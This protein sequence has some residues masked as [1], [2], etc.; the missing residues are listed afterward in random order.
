LNYS[1]FRDLW[2]KFILSSLGKGSKYINAPQDDNK[3]HM[4][5]DYLLT[6]KQSNEQ[7]QYI[8]HTSYYIEKD[9]I[10]FLPVYISWV[11]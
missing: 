9:Y 3:R 4:E 7:T 1:G 6:K 8:L 11:L 5:I 10:V 2:K